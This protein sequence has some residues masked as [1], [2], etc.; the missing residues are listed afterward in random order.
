MVLVL[1]DE[2]AKTSIFVDIEIP[3]DNNLE[4]TSAEKKRKYLPLAV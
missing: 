3:L 4:T 1:F 2:K